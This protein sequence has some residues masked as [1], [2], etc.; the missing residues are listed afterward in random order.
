MQ[1]EDVMLLTKD[2]MIELKDD[3]RRQVAHF[4]MNAASTDCIFETFW[5]AFKLFKLLPMHGP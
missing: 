2:Q 3:F 5:Q 4:V 1:Y